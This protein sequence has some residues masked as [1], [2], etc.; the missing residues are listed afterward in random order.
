MNMHGTRTLTHWGALRADTQEHGSNEDNEVL[1][2][3]G[4]GSKPAEVPKDYV[5]LCRSL[6][7]F[8]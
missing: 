7:T 8:H 5:D 6:H 1:H 3:F 2:F 4:C